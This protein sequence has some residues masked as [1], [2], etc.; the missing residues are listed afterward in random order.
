[1]KYE[2]K[3]GETF[4][5]ISFKAYGSIDYA[6]T[7]RQSNPLLIAYEIDSVLPEKIILGIPILTDNTPY[8]EPTDLTIE[9]A[10]NRW[11]TQNGGKNTNSAWFAAIEW[12][13]SQIK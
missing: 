12:Y 13:K 10:W 3:I 9:L 8:L 7:I 5:S 1:M 11:Y 2:T 4:R 6:E